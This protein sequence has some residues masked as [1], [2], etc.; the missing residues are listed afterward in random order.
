METSTTILT[1]F[2]RAMTEF[3][4]AMDVDSP[5]S[6]VLPQE[7]TYFDATHTCIHSFKSLGLWMFYPSMRKI[8]WLA[9]IDIHSENAKDI[10][11]FFRLFNEILQFETGNPEYK[12]NPRAFMCDEGSANYRAIQLVYGDDF[13]KEC[14]VGCQWHFKNDTIRKARQVGPDMRDLFTKLCTSLCTVTKY[15][16]I[17]SWIGSIGGMNAPS[18]YLVPFCGGGLPGVNLSEQG[19]A[20]WRSRTM[21]LVHAAKY[22]V[23]SMILQNKKLFKFNQ[24]MEKSDGKGSS[25]GMRISCDWGDQC[26]IGEDLV[27]ILSDEEALEA[28]ANEA[29][30]PTWFLPKEKQD[31]S[32]QLQSSPCL[33]TKREQ[34]RTP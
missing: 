15:K 19:N 32:H 9:S 5:V 29:E 16:I 4:I 34:L 26:K 31:T 2:S 17:N 27:D 13:T 7:N 14:I 8:L 24:N 11:T 30:N 3:A 20:W 23:A 25:Q 21:R 6:S 18:I 1:L 12:F 10:M 22:D 33:L 28:E